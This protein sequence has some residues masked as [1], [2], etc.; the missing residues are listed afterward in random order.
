LANPQKREGIRKTLLNLYFSDRSLGFEEILKSAE[1]YQRQ[2]ELDFYENRAADW[3]P[4]YEREA[5]RGT[6]FKT[7]IPKIYNY[8]CA[9]SRQRI[10][11]ADIQMID[12]CHI[13]PWSETKDDSIQNGIAL[14][15]TLHRAFDRGIITINPDYTVS[16]SKDISESAYSPF[17]LSQFEGRRILLPEREE[18]WPW[19]G[20]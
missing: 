14:T 13:R 19:V 6:Q 16:V 8:T 11:V 9:I 18:W 10:I 15:P 12:A 5:L 1:V 3:L 17:N 7:Y 20:A 2:L 4:S